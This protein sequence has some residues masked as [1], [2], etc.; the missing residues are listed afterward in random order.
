MTGVLF[1]A[2]L[3]IQGAEAFTI[4]HTNTYAIAVCQDEK[5]AVLTTQVS[6]MLRKIDWRSQ[7]S[8]LNTKLWLHELA[9]DEDEAFL[10]DG[11]INGFQLVDCN[12]QFTEVNMR[13]YKSATST[14]KLL[15]EKTIRNSA[16][17]LRYYGYKTYGGKRFGS[18]S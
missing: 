5:L 14:F 10:A 3:T 9:G 11:I 1:A 12:T 2:I 8:P 17:Q 18:D 4:V 13:N 6:F 15:V 7:I 16:R